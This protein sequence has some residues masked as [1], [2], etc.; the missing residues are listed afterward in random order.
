LLARRGFPA[1]VC[2]VL[3]AL[4]LTFPTVFFKTVEFG[5]LTLAPA[6]PLALPLA[7]GEARW[8]GFLVVGSSRSRRGQSAIA[9]LALPGP[10]VLTALLGRQPG[11]G[12]VAA[13]P[14]AVCVVG[15]ACYEWISTA[16]NRTHAQVVMTGAMWDRLTWA[17]ACPALALAGVT[18]LL[19]AGIGGF[20]VRT[21]LGG[22]PLWH[23]PC[24]CR[25]SSCGHRGGG[26]GHLLP[27][28]RLRCTS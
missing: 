5:A 7:R 8:I 9:W 6:V 3:A 22:P 17:S 25:A 23:R 10:S 14:G 21:M 26:R 13:L 2:P 18:F 12:R 20:F 1:L 15:L 24:S 28:G 19:A 11:G 27:R 4:G 16:M